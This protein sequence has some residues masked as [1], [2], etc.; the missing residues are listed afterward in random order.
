MEVEQLEK[1]SQFVTKDNHERVCGYVL[2]CS[3]YLVD[4]DE[5]RKILTIAYD[6]YLKHGEYCNALRVRPDRCLGAWH[7]S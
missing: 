7:P 2:S 3:D 5:R 6:A 1:S 4:Q